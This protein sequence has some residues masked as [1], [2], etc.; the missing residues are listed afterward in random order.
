MTIAVDIPSIMTANSASPSPSVT[1]SITLSAPGEIIVVCAI[2]NG[3]TSGTGGPAFSSVSDSVN[4]AYTKYASEGSSSHSYEE[5]W[6]VYSPTAVSGAIITVTPISSAFT[7]FVAYGISGAPSTNPWDANSAGT[8]STGES[9]TTTNADDLIITCYQPYLADQTTPEGSGWTLASHTGYGNYCFVEYQVVSS[10]GTYTGTL[11]SG[12]TNTGG[13]I[14]AM[15]AAGGAL[16]NL[17]ALM[18][19]GT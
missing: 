10:T 2:T 14:V 18:G 13:V 5:V 1:G 7:T 12:E 16:P 3:G 4:G 11:S 9:I 17:R 6:W 19:V 15:K 8:T